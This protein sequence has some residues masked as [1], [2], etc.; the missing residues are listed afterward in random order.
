[1]QLIL[2]AKSPCCSTKKDVLIGDTDKVD[3][4][5]IFTAEGLTYKCGWCGKP[6]ALPNMAVR[7]QIP[8]PPKTAA[9]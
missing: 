4:D 1:M 3:A 7:I 9:V 5:G 2:K 8:E 6:V